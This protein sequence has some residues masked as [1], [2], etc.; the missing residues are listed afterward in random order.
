MRALAVAAG[1][2]FALAIVWGSLTPSPPRIDVAHIDKVEHLLAYGA[3]MFWFG[4]LYRGWR[5]RLAYAAL[6][7][8]LGVGLEFAQRA[9]GYRDFEVA[10]M[11][12]DAVGVMLG[13]A[14]SA[15][16]RA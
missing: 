15:T 6:W 5:A 4:M 11:V 3:L 8:A 10:D 2:A 12:A 13:L 7:I 16:L 9:T 1:W 14:L